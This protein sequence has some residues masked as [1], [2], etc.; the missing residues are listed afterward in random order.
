MKR[1]IRRIGFVALLSLAFPFAL[2]R[3]EKRV[4]IKTVLIVQNAKLGDMVCTTPMFRA[5]KKTLPASKLLVF[6]NPLNEQILAG[7]PYVDEYIKNEL[8]LFEIYTILKR[9]KI[10]AICMTSPFFE[11]LAVAIITG[12]PII[13]V[14]L[15]RGGWSPY[16]T[17]PFTILSRYVTTCHH[18]MGKYVPREYLRL[19]EPIGIF[20][21]DTRKSIFFTE[22]AQ[23]N[24][25]IFLKQNNIDSNDQFIIGIL[26]GAGNEIKTWAPEK[27]AKLMGLIAERPKTVFILLGTEKDRER[28]EIIKRNVSKEVQIVD[29]IGQLSIDELKACISKL[30]MVIG[31]DSGPQYIAEALDIPTIDIVG[32]VDEREQPPMGT[33]HRI[34]KVKRKK[35]E[36][37]VMNARVY[38]EKEARRQTDEISAE[39]VYTEFKNLQTTLENFSFNSK[40]ATKYPV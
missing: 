31:A 34:V 11:M 25:D 14:P 23:K 2:F 1:Y 22:T 18:T 6:G 35:P 26:P 32:P 3:T 39:A 20:E 37:Y 21:E 28:G 5:I 30:N 17:K 19:L 8:S 13:T 7:N 24:M 27:F 15:V 38:D 9:K 12:V 10:D 16:V 33:F 36:L 4:E 29:C 40:L